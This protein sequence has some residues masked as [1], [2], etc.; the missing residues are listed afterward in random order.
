MF[1]ING[2]M[3]HSPSSFHM[4]D[5]HDFEQCARQVH[6]VGL[7]NQRRRARSPQLYD[8]ADLSNYVCEEWHMDTRQSVALGGTHHGHVSQ[9]VE[10]GR[11]FLSTGRMCSNCHYI[12]SR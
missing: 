11:S 10:C 2:Q 9:E 4:D 6:I 7:R 5:C 3:I 1:G 8:W 12:S